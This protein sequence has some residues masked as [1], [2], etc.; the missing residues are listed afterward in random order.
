MYNLERSATAAFSSITYRGMQK[1][2]TASA[3]HFEKNFQNF[4]ILALGRNVDNFIKTLKGFGNFLTDLYSYSRKPFESEVA[5][6]YPN[7]MILTYKESF[8]KTL[9]F[10][11]SNVAFRK[12]Q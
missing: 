9:S 3:L 7:V 11:S 2:D 1:T 6:H 12:E 4:L 10:F 8:N 5:T